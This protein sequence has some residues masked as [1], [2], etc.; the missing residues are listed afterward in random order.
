MPF[1]EN[2]DLIDRS[3][4]ISGSFWVVE[5][6][7][8]K[9]HNNDS[10]VALPEYELK[11]LRVLNQNHAT[12]LSGNDKSAD[13][14]CSHG[15]GTSHGAATNPEGPLEE[16]EVSKSDEC[17]IESDWSPEYSVPLEEATPST[18][19]GRGDAIGFPKF[20]VKTAGG[21]SML[22][23][24]LRHARG[25]HST[26]TSTHVRQP[27]GFEHLGV[28]NLVSN[29]QDHTQSGCNEPR[30]LTELRYLCPPGHSGCGGRRE[31]PFDAKNPRRPKQKTLKI[32]SCVDCVFVPYQTESYEEPD[33]WVLFDELHQK[34]TF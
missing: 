5:K 1:I 25:I 22:S 17:A 33:D 3:S 9:H 15:L 34:A 24:L 31:K 16:T 2:L 28:R 32:Q 10:G 6:V 14:H 23:H 19:G 18:N 30:P 7:E 12:T 4:T 20:R 11:G 8:K 13:L 26:R 27:P 29:P 21:P